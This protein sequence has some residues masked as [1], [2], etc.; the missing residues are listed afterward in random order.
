MTGFSPV[1]SRSR[2][3]VSFA[4][5][6]AGLLLVASEASGQGAAGIVGHIDG[7]RFEGDQFHIWGWAGQRGNRES[8]EVHIY[9]D[10]PATAT[11]KGTFVLGGQANLASEA[12]IDELCQ[13]AR[14]KHR[15]QI[16]LPS[17]ILAKYKGKKLYVH[18]VVNGVEGAVIAGSGGFQFPDPPIFRVV[19]DT[20]PPM[21][22]AYLSSAQHPRVFMTP[23]DM[24]DLVQRIDRPG[25]FSAQSFAR[26]AARVRSDLAAKTDWEATYS[27]CDIDVYLHAFSIE[28]TGGYAGEIRSEQQLRAALNL[29]PGTPPPH[30]AAIVA[31][32]L[33]LYA[34]LVAAGAPAPAAAP[35][36][37]AAAALAK[38]ILLAW[39]TRG[40]RG[41]NGDFFRPPDR[42]CNGSGQAVFPGAL[43][44]SRGVVY[45]VHAQDLLQGRHALSPEETAQLDRFHSQMYD[46]IST[47]RNEEVRRALASSHPDEIYSNQTANHLVALLA[48]ARLLDDERR[49][50]AALEGDATIPVSLPWT[51]LFNY[52]VYGTAD[53]PLLRITPNASEDPRQSSAAYATKVV[54]PGEINDRFRNLNPLQGMGYPV[55]TLE[56]LF[57]AAEIL[58]IAG[59]DAYGYRGFRQQSIEMAAQY[60]AGYAKHAGFYQTVTAENAGACSDY[61][62]Y[63]GKVVNDVESVIV[64]GAYRFPGNALLA[65][66][67]GVA[68]ARYAQE[69]NLNTIHFGRWSD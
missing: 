33:A 38:K 23:A 53:T 36:A 24:S 52:V 48:A 3:F 41:A 39:A 29:P 10:H 16:D 61:R 7:L 46:W 25:T 22:G 9:A 64:I 63:V 1:L 30:G 13:A 44:I 17:R 35:D 62:Q 49:F 65:E 6:A 8:I 47:T 54:A 60:Y 26:L 68:Q 58:R 19:P 4:A 45:S 69:D 57:S 43:Q 14:G 27:G 55:Y 11:P 42:F 51:R 40:F 5:V 28:S 21:S 56:H 50:R 18:G 67:N 59:F 32:R 34:A 37:D 31:S 12:V 2:L 20:F 66:L 15:F